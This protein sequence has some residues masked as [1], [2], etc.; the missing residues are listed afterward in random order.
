MQPH[1]R[2]IEG[3]TMRE[4]DTEE[5]GEGAGGQGD[6]YLEAERRI[7]RVGVTQYTKGMDTGPVAAGGDAEEDWRNGS[8]LGCRMQSM[9]NTDKMAVT[10]EGGSKVEVRVKIGTRKYRVELDTKMRYEQVKA[11]VGLL[12]GMTMWNFWRRKGRSW[13]HTTASGRTVG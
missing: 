9:W 10:G 11:I 4:G 13:D 12:P 8:E 1:R 3:G 5:A 6:T 2:E 7:D